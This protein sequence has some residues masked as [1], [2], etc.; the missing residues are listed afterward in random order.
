M[1]S[2][3]R[4]W[5]GYSPRLCPIKFHRLTTCESGAHNSESRESTRFIYKQ[6]SDLRK[7]P[8]PEA[9]SISGPFMPEEL[10]ATLQHLKPGKSSGLDSFFPE[11]MHHAGLALKSWLCDFLTSCMC[12]LKNPSIWRI[13]LIVAIPKT[14]KSLGSQRATA[15]YPCCVSLSRSLRDLSTAHLWLI[16]PIVDPLLPRKQACLQHG[17]LG[18]PDHLTFFQGHFFQ[19]GTVSCVKRSGDAGT[20]AWLYAP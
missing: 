2:W 14:E 4:P 8:T 19:W 16:R 11:F 7:V 15:L 12:Q 1:K 6:L 9:N 20:A 17:R 5:S 18:L 3:W 13:A 10:A